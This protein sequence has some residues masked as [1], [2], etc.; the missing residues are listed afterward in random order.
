MTMRPSSSIAAGTTEEIVIAP[1][2][3][4]T[5]SPS[6]E[7]SKR[8]PSKIG[9]VV[10]G[11]SACVVTDSALTSSLEFKINRIRVRL[12]MKVLQEYIRLS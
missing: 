12:L 4:V 11:E 6:S 9:M 8:T 5:R 3:Q 10:R 2:E 7:A 1:S